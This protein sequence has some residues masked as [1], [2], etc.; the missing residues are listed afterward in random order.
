MGGPEQFEL[1]PFQRLQQYLILR[2]C[3]INTVKVN[4]TLNFRQLSSA[5]AVFIACEEFVCLR[6]TLISA[7]LVE[8][9][10]NS[11]QLQLLVAFFYLS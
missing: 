7:N 6:R 9:L 4:L 2:F 11:E 3:S 10:G 5:C 8:V 1:H